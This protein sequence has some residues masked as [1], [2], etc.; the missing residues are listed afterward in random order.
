MKAKEIIFRPEFGL[1]STITARYPQD[2]PPLAD[3]GDVKKMQGFLDHLV[4]P[5]SLLLYLAGQRKRFT[6]NAT[7]QAA[8]ST[9]DRAFV[10]ESK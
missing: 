8:R 9:T 2:L 1:I 5:F 7:N 10:K 3:R 6:C 4:H